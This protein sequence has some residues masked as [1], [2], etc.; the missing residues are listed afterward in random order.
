MKVLRDDWRGEAVPVQRFL[1]SRGYPNLSPSQTVL[2][3]PA[4]SAAVHL[5]ARL[6]ITVWGANGPSSWRL[7]ARV[8]TPPRDGAIGMAGR[9]QA[10][11]VAAHRDPSAYA[12]GTDPLAIDRGYSY[13]RA[14][15]GSSD[16]ALRAG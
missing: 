8:S 2:D 11:P 13:R 16:A 9:H 7:P 3:E 6:S 10:R 4:P 12:D 5:P 14:S 15:I 1:S